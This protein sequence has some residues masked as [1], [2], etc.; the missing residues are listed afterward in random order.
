MRPP[1][2]SGWRLQSWSS[3]EAQLF[4]NN[5]FFFEEGGEEESLLKKKKKSL[6]PSAGGAGPGRQA[7]AGTDPRED[8]L[9]SPQTPA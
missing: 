4:C 3:S 6:Q 2:A 8:E 7:G 1:G 5:F 9:R